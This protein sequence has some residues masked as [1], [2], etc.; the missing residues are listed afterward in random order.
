MKM[1]FNL[2]LQK[3]H[4]FTLLTQPKEKPSKDTYQECEL[5]V[6]VIHCDTAYN[7]GL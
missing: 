5:L 3:I 7:Y 2:V 6:M 1:S 4:N